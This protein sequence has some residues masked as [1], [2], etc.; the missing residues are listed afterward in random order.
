MRSLMGSVDVRL[1]GDGTVVTLRYRVDGRDGSD[2]GSTVQAPGAVAPARTG[3]EPA[4]S[5]PAAGTTRGS[6]TRFRAAV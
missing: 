2:G 5:S 3:Q 6:T 1:G 4:G